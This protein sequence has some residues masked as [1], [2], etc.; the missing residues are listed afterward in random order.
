MVKLSLS[1]IF[2]FPNKRKITPIKATIQR[3]MQKGINL[4]YC[5]TTDLPSNEIAIAKLNKFKRQVSPKLKKIAFPNV[6]VGRIIKIDFFILK[7]PFYI[8]V[9][10]SVG[11]HIISKRDENARKVFENYLLRLL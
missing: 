6:K 1:D 9:F 4:G 8:F 2:I 11:K 7:Y 3:I 10:F 5:S